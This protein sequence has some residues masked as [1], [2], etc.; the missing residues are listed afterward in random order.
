MK[1]QRLIASDILP[2]IA[3]MVK[4]TGVCLTDPEGLAEALE[5]LD[6]SC[7]Q[8]HQRLD[9]EGTLFEWYVPVY[10]GCFALPQDCRQVRQISI[11]GVPARQRS[12]WYIG[13][14][15]AGSGVEGCCAPYEC[16]DLGDFYIP[17]YLPKRDGIRI[18]LIA[19]EEADA[20]KQVIVEVTDRTGTP[21]RETLTL[22]ANG[23]PATMAAVAYDVTYF[24][25]PK[26][27]G[28]VSLQLQ[29]DD[30]QRFY[31]A[32]YL[33]DTQEGL[34][35]RK[36][37]PQ[38]WAGC[39]IARIFGK[40]RYVKID[41]EDQILPY[42]DPIA[43]GWACSAIAAWRRRE[44]PTYSEHMQLALESLK[45]QMLDADSA[46]AVKQMNIRTN[47]ANG[48]WAGGCRNWN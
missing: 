4:D 41:S 30:G 17:Q 20:G 38:R 11:N 23:Q 9:S 10:S 37:F 35:R 27:L 31:F 47:F 5:F 25:K 2:Q 14:I 48:S 32:D 42:N 7:R 16:R 44:G 33:P 22:L 46:G 40:T 13:K 24:F 45:A 29:Y 3:P 12:E 39:N 8:L 34:F 19:T 18:A 21:K 28:N 15:A 43:V 1:T 6:M 26:T 36:Q